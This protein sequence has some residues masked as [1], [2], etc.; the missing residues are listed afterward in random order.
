MAESFFKTATAPTLQGWQAPGSMDFQAAF[1]RAGGWALPRTEAFPDTAKLRERLQELKASMREGA[2]IG[3]DLRG[4]RDSADSVMAAA[5]EAGV[6]FLLHTAELPPSLAMLRHANMPRLVAVQNPE[7]AA[8]AKAGGAAALLAR[9]SDVAALRKFG[10]PVMAV[11][12]TEAEARQAMADGAIG[13][14]P[15]TP[16]VLDSS[17]LAAFRTRLMAGLDSMAQAFVRR[18]A[19]TLPRLRI[20]NLDLAYPIQQGGMGVGVSWEGLAGAVAS[21]GCVGLVSA[22]GTGYHGSANPTMRLGRPDGS[23]SLNPPK[24]LEWIVRAARERSEGRG[25]VGVNILCAI[26]GYESAVRASIAGGAQLIV[27]GAGLPLALPGYV[28]DADVALVPIVSSGRA[29][30]VICK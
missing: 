8:Q 20:R 25:A 3:L 14:Q 26:E 19:C 1:L 16:G 24:A 13:L 6:A 10:L 28:G 9:A 27:S 17:P 2:K 11:A 21:A 23:D 29:L 5:R 7:E 4:L 15:R 12:D 22:I 30:S 18:G